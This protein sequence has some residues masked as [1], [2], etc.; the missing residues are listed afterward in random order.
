M[1]PGSR[2]LKGPRV[3]KEQRLTPKG[4][5]LGLGLPLWAKSYTELSPHFT[6]RDG[7][8]S[9]ASKGQVDILSCRLRG[10]SE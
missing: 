7:E 2:A 5:V 9:W 1:V 3:C 6:C 10:P 4:N 8:S